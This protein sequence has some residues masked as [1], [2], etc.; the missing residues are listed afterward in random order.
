MIN[1]V[2]R[3]AVQRTLGR[4]VIGKLD[5]N[6]Q[7]GARC[8]SFARDD[9][10]KSVE[11]AHVVRHTTDDKR[12]MAIWQRQMH[13]QE[14]IGPGEIRERTVAAGGLNTS[15]EQDV[16]PIY[17][18]IQADKPLKTRILAALVGKSTCGWP[19]T[20]PERRRNAGKSC[21]M[22]LEPSSAM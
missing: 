14:T 15:K 3:L 12:G 20:R 5:Q 7:M 13:L 4:D 8:A 17:E 10:R 1:C 19:R 16:I 11:M 9:N 2:M 6:I 18:P 21:G 22:A